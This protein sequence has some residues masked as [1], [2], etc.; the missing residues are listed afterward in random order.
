MLLPL[1][2]DH[3]GVDGPL[4]QEGDPV[5]GDAKGGEGPLQ[6]GQL[7]FGIDQGKAL[8]LAVP[9][10]PLGHQLDSIFLPIHI[11]GR[12]D[13][14]NDWL[15]HAFDSP[16]VLFTKYKRLYLILWGL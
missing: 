10:D 15:F 16:L 1:L 4:P 11:L 13:G 3:L 12:F 6:A 2:E 5:G 7:A 14:D 8:L 9:E